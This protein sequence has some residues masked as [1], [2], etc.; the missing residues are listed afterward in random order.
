[1]A[2]T[3]S[4]HAKCCSE[5]CRPEELEEEVTEDKRTF[6][7]ALKGLE[8]TRKYNCQFDTEGNI[9]VLCNKAESGMHKLKT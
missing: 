9:I 5:K 1:M 6:L 7:D 3:F 4:V 2:G 8:A